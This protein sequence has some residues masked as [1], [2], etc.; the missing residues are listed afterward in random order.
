VTANDVT[1][2]NPLRIR[3]NYSGVRAGDERQASISLTQ[4][5]LSDGAR[6]RMSLCS[7]RR[8]GCIPDYLREK[9]V[10]RRAGKCAETIRFCNT[11]A[12]SCVRSVITPFYPPL[13]ICDRSNE[14]GKGTKTRFLID[15]FISQGTIAPTEVK[16]VPLK[17]MP[18]PQMGMLDLNSTAPRFPFTSGK[19]CDH[20]NTNALWAPGLSVI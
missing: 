7:W 14:R 3:G 12:R 13:F 15:I 16:A 9:N 4:L 10:D 2:N 11:N 18:R 19:Y 17:R 1:G 20:V 5:A 8:F 6:E